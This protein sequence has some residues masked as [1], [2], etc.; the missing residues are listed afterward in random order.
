MWVTCLTLRSLPAV[1]G[2]GCS[3]FSHTCLQQY[4]LP[5][6]VWPLTHMHVGYLF[7]AQ[8]IAG[9]LRRAITPR[10]KGA[11]CQFTP[12]KCMHCLSTMHPGDPCV[13]PSRRLGR[14]LRAPVVAPA[15]WPPAP[16]PPT[17]ARCQPAPWRQ[18]GRSRCRPRCCCRCCP[19]KSRGRG[20]LL[21]GRAGRTVNGVGSWIQE[22][23]GLGRDE[24]LKGGG[25]SRQGLVVQCADAERGTHKTREPV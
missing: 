14:C 19:R 1:S 21:A 16:P 13:S 3:P 2:G 4:G 24:M 11:L 10:V 7:D 18:H 9:G 8:V 12:T 15:S 5:C 25:Q 17:S 22:V 23:V 20:R 6:S